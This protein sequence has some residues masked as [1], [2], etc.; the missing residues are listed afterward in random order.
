MDKSVFI[1]YPKYFS[2]EIDWMPD[3]GRR[4]DWP[5]LAAERNIE[6]KIENE[7]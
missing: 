1:I 6:N 5:F 4:G 2:E 3:A 7:C